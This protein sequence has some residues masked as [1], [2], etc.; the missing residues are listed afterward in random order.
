MNLILCI[1]SFAQEHKE[2]VKSVILNHTAQQFHARSLQSCWCQADV[3]WQ[4]CPVFVS[5]MLGMLAVV[6][7]ADGISY[8]WS[9]SPLQTPVPGRSPELDT[10]KTAQLSTIWWPLS[11]LSPL[12]IGALNAFINMTKC[13]KD[14]NFTE[15]DNNKNT[16]L[17]ISMYW[18]QNKHTHT[19]TYILWCSIPLLE[20]HILWKLKRT[21]LY[22]VL[23]SSP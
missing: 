18:Q 12:L 16:F 6:V 2:T 10:P 4:L 17:S 14:S 3:V 21:W 13:N 9:Q 11:L 20:V 23:I 5:V 1:C 19:Y 7:T 15:Q 22:L 8:A